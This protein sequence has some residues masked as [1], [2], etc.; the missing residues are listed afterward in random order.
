MKTRILVALAAVYLAWGSTYLAILYGVES[1]PPFL[2]AGTRFL[3]AG[4]IV[5]AWRRLAGDAAPSRKQW[6]SAGIIGVLLLVGGNG[7]VTWAEQRVASGIAALLVASVPLWMVMLD[8]LRRGGSRPNWQTGLGVLVGLAG[9]GILI[10]PAQWSGNGLSLDRFGVIALLLAALLWAI[11]SLYSRGADL[12]SSALLGTGM[13]MLAGSAGLFLMATVTGE[14]GRLDLEAVTLRSLGGLAYLI[15]FGSLVGFVAYT[16]LLRVAPTPLV[17]T[18]AYVNP[19]IAVLLGSLF[20]QEAFTP[21][22]LLAAAVIV[23]AVVLINSGRAKSSQLL[24]KRM[25]LAPTSGED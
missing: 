24:P 5:Y 12:P 13:E 11:G 8:A 9:I 4:A 15:V 19:L 2:L 16:W 10:S 3:I 14:W 23:S 22:I 17:S 18:Y 7:G 25:V 20:A 21:R 6:R 1:I